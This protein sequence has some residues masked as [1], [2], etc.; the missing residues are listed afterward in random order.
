MK[1]TLLTLSL[2]CLIM[3]TG[4]AKQPRPAES[5]S[6]AEPPFLDGSLLDE[7]AAPEVLSDWRTTTS[8]QD[9]FEYVRTSEEFRGS[10][11]GRSAQA[12]QH[13]GGKVDPKTAGMLV[14]LAKTTLG[15]PYVFGGSSRSGFDCSG[16]VRWTYSHFGI[17][18]PRSAA[19]QAQMGRPIRNQNA[20][21]AGDLVTF[22]HPRRGYHI[23]IYVGDG[24]FIH[25]PQR[26]KNVTIV[27]LDDDYFRRIY[28]GA[29]RLDT[30][31]ISNN[32]L[33]EVEDLV[34]AY[35][36]D[37][38]RRKRLAD[39]R[40]SR[41]G[42]QLVS[43]RTNSGSRDG[44]ARRADRRKNKNDKADNPREKR[45]YSADSRDAR[46]TN[47]VTRVSQSRDEAR[48]SKEKR[49]QDQEITSQQ[50]DRRKD[51]VRESTQK[52]RDRQKDNAKESAQKQRDRQKDNARETAQKQRDRQKDNTR[53]A[54]QKQRDRQKDNAREAAQK[55][56]DRQKDNARADNKDRLRVEVRR[57]NDNRDDK[58]PAASK[59]AQ[60]NRDDKK[61]DDK[62]R[63]DKKRDDKKRDG[64]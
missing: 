55:Q 49:R 48:S 42:N 14:R 7:D 20:L 33:E 35:K 62:K 19:E 31:D 57:S 40:H 18:L 28:T 61:R 3:L 37:V 58:K 17:N 43:S 44:D 15:T 4:C 29:R 26:N 59:P 1:K 39:A 2:A 45:R 12:S 22:R 34:N 30:D 11:K 51:N 64:K 27:S 46:R 16:L 8:A 56:R 38:S 23:G 36:E 6:P 5:G 21:Q 50:R 60:N 41:S 54:T 63:D 24:K 10:G 25:S 13:Y 52:Q 32:R 9:S 53:E 47:S